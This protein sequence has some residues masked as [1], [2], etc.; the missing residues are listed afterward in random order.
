MNEIKN[1]PE[2]RPGIYVMQNIMVRGGGRWPAGGKNK[3]YKLKEKMKKGKE[4]R[5]KIT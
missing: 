1:I 5:R 3:N 4:N 2:I